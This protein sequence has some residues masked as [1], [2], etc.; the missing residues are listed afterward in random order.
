[1]FICILFDYRDKIC[2][3]D[4][5]PIAGQ[6][7]QFREPDSWSKYTTPFDNIIILTNR[8]KRSKYIHTSKATQYPPQLAPSSLKSKGRRDY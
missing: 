3:Y 4:E 1:M 2:V 6:D 7:I 8:I 5:H